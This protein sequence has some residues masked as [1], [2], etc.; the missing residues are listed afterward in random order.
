MVFR[1]KLY[2]KPIKNGQGFNP[3]KYPRLYK[4][5]YHRI[6]NKKIKARGK[7]PRNLK[8]HR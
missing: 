6:Q 8:T 3:G 2:Y 1:E 4:L 5:Y 7:N